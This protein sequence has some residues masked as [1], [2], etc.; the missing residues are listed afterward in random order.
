VMSNIQQAASVTVG[1]TSYDPG[2]D[3]GREASG[4][5]RS[6]TKSSDRLEH[7]ISALWNEFAPSGGQQFRVLIY[8]RPAILKPEIREHLYLI[9]REALINALRHSGAPNIEAEVEYSPR[10]LR[11]IVR[12]DGRGINPR[13]LNWE[14]GSQ[15]GL[16]TMRERA[17]RAGAE[18]RVWSRPG[19]GTEV[20]VSVCEEIAADHQ[21]A[22]KE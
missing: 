19:C 8:G 21:Y 6:S 2:R 17:E 11:I 5:Y 9:V 4:G 16:L 3:H 12:D 7:A 15:W 10:R 1:G 18:L 13:V 22:M 14:R 20:E